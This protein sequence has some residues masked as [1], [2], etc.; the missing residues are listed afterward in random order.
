MYCRHSLCLVV[1]QIGS[2]LVLSF[3]LLCHVNSASAEP[4]NLWI[5]L[6][7]EWG[8]SARTNAILQV[9]VDG[10]HI[11]VHDSMLGSLTE[12]VSK[13]QKAV[14][15]DEVGEL[16]KWKCADYTHVAPD[17]PQLIGMNFRLCV[18]LLSTERDNLLIEYSRDE[19]GPHEL[20][21]QTRLSISM[22]QPTCRAQV[23]SSQ[24]KA[25]GTSLL[26]VVRR[27]ES[28]IYATHCIDTV[29]GRVCH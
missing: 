23:I 16:N 11:F 18:R 3:C 22:L 15:I 5:T 8:N 21:E 17:I 2:A 29:G 20:I 14:S 24:T 4:R 7:G 13:N 27:V 26:P 19:R 6:Q 1:R 25:D 10:D 9:I 28:C 12:S